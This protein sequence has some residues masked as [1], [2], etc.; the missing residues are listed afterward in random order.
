MG[1]TVRNS[2][3][4]SASIESAVQVGA[5][6][7]RIFGQ[8]IR[9]D[10]TDIHIEPQTEALA[11]RFR[12]QGALSTELTLEAKVARPLAMQLKQLADMDLKQTKAPQEGAFTQVHNHHTYRLSVDTMP[13]I[14]GERIVI[15]IWTRLP[16]RP[17]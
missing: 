17:S 3:H 4:R 6:W 10:A 5:I 13:L 7:R 8:A 15:H 9:T 12:R 2:T 16:S 1:G 14:S 11:I